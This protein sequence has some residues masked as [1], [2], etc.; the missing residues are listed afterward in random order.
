[1]T[2]EKSEDCTQR[3][4]ESDVP[5]VLLP[6]LK[7]LVPL[8]A[9][10]L[11][12]Y[13]SLVIGPIVKDVADVTEIARQVQKESIRIHSMLNDQTR[14]VEGLEKNGKEVESLVS[15][16]QGHAE[17]DNTIHVNLET[18]IRDVA[19][20]IGL[21]TEQYNALHRDVDKLSLQLSIHLD[22]DEPLRKR[23]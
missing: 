6:W 16:L 13:V 12:L 20:R 11:G 22:R 14:R 5:N 17:S 1:M 4:R 3:R 10:G 15:Q 18:N 7:F 23:K 2:E 8:S 9:S 21:V 19:N